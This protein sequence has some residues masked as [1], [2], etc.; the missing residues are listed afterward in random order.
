MSE[1]EHTTT[2]VVPIDA[3]EQYGERGEIGKLGER[4]KTVMPGGDKLS[5][6]S[7]LAAG[8][9]AFLMDANFMTGDLYAYED[10]DGKLV[11]VEGYKILVRWAEKKSTYSTSDRPLSDDERKAEGVEDGDIAHYLWLLRDDKREQIGEFVKLGAPFREAFELVAM[12]AVGVVTRREMWSAKYNK[13]IDPPVGW[14]WPQVAVKRALKTAIRWSYGT[15]SPHELQAQAAKLISEAS[16]GADIRIEDLRIARLEAPDAGSA[17]RLRLAA[18][19]AQDRELKAAAKKRTAEEHAELLEHNNE[20]LY[21]PA[22][23][24]G[25]GDEPEDGAFREIPEEPPAKAR[26]DIVPPEGA[27]PL[28]LGIKT[29]K[30]LFIAAN[31]EIPYYN[32]VKHCYNTLRKEDVF[33]PAFEWNRPEDDYGKLLKA[34]VEYARLNTGGTKE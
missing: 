1:K 28:R 31:A 8:Q 21:G 16:G 34:L 2:A 7:A 5:V 10:K 29:P 30:E 12:R 17:G 26:L 6:T 19:H 3:P 14:T 20:I 11:L 18:M 23:F 33:D 32:D 27:E 22:D 13:A 15:P 24:E 9:A 4:I 25:F